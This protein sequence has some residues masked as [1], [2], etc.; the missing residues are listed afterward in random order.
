[1]NLSI[2]DQR[3]VLDAIGEHG[4]AE[5]CSSIESKL[6]READYLDFLGIIAIARDFAKGPTN[7]R[8]CVDA[9]K[10]RMR[11]FNHLTL[12]R[13]IE[14]GRE[15]LDEM[16]YFFERMESESFGLY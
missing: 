11:L 14:I 1:M 5:E 16:N 4:G 9:V 8:K 2:E 13:S 6:L 10:K 3:I 12:P 15:R 7:L